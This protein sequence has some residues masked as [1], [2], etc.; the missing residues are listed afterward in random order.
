LKVLAN[1]VNEIETQTVNGILQKTIFS[2]VPELLGLSLQE[3]A[4]RFI[5][6]QGLDVFN[7]AIA[8]AIADAFGGNKEKIQEAIANGDYEFL[9]L[10]PM[11]RAESNNPAGSTP[12]SA[13]ARPSGE[14]PEA[15]DLFSRI[16]NIE[17]EQLVGK[18]VKSPAATRVVGGWAIMFLMFALNGAATSLLDERK[19]GILQRLLAA[20]VTRTQ[21]LW[22]RFLFGVVLGLVQLITVFSTGSVLYG[23]D[24]IGHIG[25]LVIISIAAAA[26]C[27]SLGMLIAS[28][29]DTPESAM[30]L[31]TFLVLT[32]S[33]LGGAW[34]PVS[35]MPP[36]MQQFSKF[37]LTYW[38]MEGFAQ[39]LWAGNTLIEILPTIGILLAI[40][41]GLMTI[42][43]WRFNRGNLFG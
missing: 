28:V 18:G 42:A 34:F 35:F 24:V 10:R 38:A 22:A 43:I 16:V 7:A 25:N 32:M 40:T 9:L 6:R 36:F 2:N 21:I 17:T 11:T 39:V 1:P 3:S 20:P 14:K 30:G 27:T 31:A 26:A 5:G 15:G 33:A 8:S 23:I 12:S 37:T 13:H 41:A 29:S 19:T 4:A